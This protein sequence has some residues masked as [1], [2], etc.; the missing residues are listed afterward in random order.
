MSG[1]KNSKGKGK[2]RK[3][4]TNAANA[5]GM[6]SP[7]QGMFLSNGKNFCQAGWIFYLDLKSASKCMQNGNTLALVS[8]SLGSVCLDQGK[9]MQILKSHLELA[10]TI[11]LTF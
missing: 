5:F 8:A 10:H 9:L 4:R 1:G 11:L 3:G 6:G 7:K 2:R